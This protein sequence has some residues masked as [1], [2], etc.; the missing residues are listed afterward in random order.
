MKARDFLIYFAYKYEGDYE[1][2]LGALRTKERIDESL[3]ATFDIA[4][5]KAITIVDEDYPDAFKVINRPPLVIFYEGDINLL[6]HLNK[7]IAIIGAREYSEY[8]EK[9]SKLFSE[10]L[11]KE[12]FTIVSGLARGIDGFAHQAAL[13]A[14][15]KTI[16]VL[17]SGIHEPYPLSNKKIYE[18]IK[19][20]GL[21]ISEYPGKIKPKPEY[22]KIRNRLVAAL[23]KGV[24][25]IEAKHKSGTVITVGYALEKGGDVYCVPERA[26]MQSG[27]NQLIKDGAYLVESAKDIIN[28]WNE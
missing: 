23:G 18:A 5:T 16:A 4:S 13:D 24:L 1:A 12:D 10:E 22:F 14:G 21:L 9:M 6:H 25:V 7:A 28:L 19:E 17:G 15:G 20:S 27:C 3:L 8:G 2:I 11:A 26:G